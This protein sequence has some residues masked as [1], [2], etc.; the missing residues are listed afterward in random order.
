MSQ[1]LVK[2]VDEKLWRKF[3]GYCIM[4]NVTVG[5]KLNK[6]LHNYLKGKMP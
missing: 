5:A 3:V 4:T 6:V 1:K 2:D